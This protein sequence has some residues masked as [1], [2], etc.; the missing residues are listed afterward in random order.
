MPPRRSL[1]FDKRKDAVN[2][3]HTGPPKSPPADRLHH[4]GPPTAKAERMDSDEPD[5]A[6][7]YDLVDPSWEE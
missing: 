3:A 6:P 5:L 2:W 7:E 1:A 4:R